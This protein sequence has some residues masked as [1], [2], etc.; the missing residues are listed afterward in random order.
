MN[1]IYALYV[2]DEN[3]VDNYVCSSDCEDS[4]TEFIDTYISIVYDLFADFDEDLAIL[5]TDKL[6]DHDYKIDLVE[7]EDDQ[8]CIITVYP[9][10]EVG[11]FN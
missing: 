2:V 6:N 10:K 5:I 11:C 1:K 7:D 9:H 4:I 8:E 3:G